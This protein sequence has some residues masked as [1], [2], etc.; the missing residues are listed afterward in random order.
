[1][2]RV[3]TQIPAFIASLPVPPLTSKPAALPADLA[4]LMQHSFKFI[5]QFYLDFDSKRDGR[6]ALL[7]LLQLTY[8]A[9]LDLGVSA[10]SDEVIPLSTAYVRDTVCEM[11]QLQGVIPQDMKVVCNDIIFAAN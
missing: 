10:G 3:Y 2:S 8:N 1:M 9:T 4:T 11:Q 6:A 5:H 7:N